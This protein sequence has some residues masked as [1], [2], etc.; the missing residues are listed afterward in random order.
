MTTLSAGS[1]ARWQPVAKT[2]GIDF[3]LTQ[4][5]FTDIGDANRGRSELKVY[6]LPKDGTVVGVHAATDAPDF[7]SNLQYWANVAPETQAGQPAVG[8]HE[9][10]LTA[11]LKPSEQRGSIVLDWQNRNLTAAS[12]HNGRP[13]IDQVLTALAGEASTAGTLTTAQVARI[14]TRLSE[15]AAALHSGR[16][17]S[18]LAL[19]QALDAVVAGSGDEKPPRPPAASQAAQSLPGAGGGQGCP[20][21][22]NEMFSR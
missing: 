10:F 21:Y 17:E 7:A 13:G 15:S 6:T 16:G 22:R 8:I 4:H 5:R 18:P 3:A 19:G 11:D 2:A 1:V 9:R 20:G 12:W 14:T